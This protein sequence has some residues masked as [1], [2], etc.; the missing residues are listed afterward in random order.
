MNDEGKTRYEASMRDF[1]NRQV[2]RSTLIRSAGIAALVA[3]IPA[4]ARAAAGDTYPTY[5]SFPQL[6]DGSM[7]KSGRYTTESLQDILN[8][9][10]TAEHFAVT[11]LTAALK[12]ASALGLMANPLFLPTVEAILAAE[13]THVQLL[14]AAGAQPLTDTF[15]VPDPKLLSDTASFFGALE[16]ADTIFVGAYLAAIREFAEMNQPYLAKIAG[17]IMGI[18]AEHRVLARTALA[19]LGNAGD[20]PPNN[21]GFETDLFL[22]VSEA[23]GLL[24]ALGFLGPNG[25]QATFPGLDAATAA[26]GPVYAALLQKTPNNASEGSTTT[27]NITAER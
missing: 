4:G 5:S 15:Y 18:E 14:T 25:T 3:A 1:L 8:V 6:P 27:T 13:I 10:Q 17:Q 23:A 21:K 16:T 24:Q 2:S 20:I 11:F 22:Y 26:T 9:A 19:I 12:N 7:A